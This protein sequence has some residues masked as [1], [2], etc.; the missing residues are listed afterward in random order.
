[1]NSLP[2]YVHMYLKSVF[3]VSSMPFKKFLHYFTIYRFFPIGIVSPKSFL[4]CSVLRPCQRV[5][6]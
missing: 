4:I 5:G 3:R 6:A 1:M 2:M